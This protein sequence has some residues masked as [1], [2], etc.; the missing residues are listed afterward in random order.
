MKM[1]MILGENPEIDGNPS[2]PGMD[3]DYLI[4]LN[5]IASRPASLPRIGR[6]DD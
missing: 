4:N 5:H 3:S 2:T 1:M 6:L